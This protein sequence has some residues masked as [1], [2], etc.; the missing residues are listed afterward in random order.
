MNLN[1]DKQFRPR[2]IDIE[3]P[4]PI[5]TDEQILQEIELENA[6]YTAISQPNRKRKV[7]RRALSCEEGVC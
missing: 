2:P 3:V 7:S 1:T 6:H 5:V 4:L